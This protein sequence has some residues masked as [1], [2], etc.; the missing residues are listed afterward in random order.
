MENICW[1]LC[2]WNGKSNVCWKMETIIATI[3]KITIKIVTKGAILGI[4]VIAIEVFPSAGI[5]VTF[6]SV[7]V[8]VGIV[9]IATEVVPTTR[10]VIL[11]LELLS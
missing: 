1:S 5:V 3:T 7:V 10:V 6:V 2:C 9:V 4:I 11:Q 8:V